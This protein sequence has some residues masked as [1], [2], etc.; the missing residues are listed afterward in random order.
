M[1]KKKFFFKNYQRLS[2]F[3]AWIT[4]PERQKGPKNEVNRPEGLQ[5]EVGAR[6]ASRLLG[7]GAEKNPVFFM[8]FCQ[9][10]RA[11]VSEGSEKTILLF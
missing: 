11:G 5:L 7:K 10:P 6:R 2:Y 9:G 3:S 8:I 1:A 4:R